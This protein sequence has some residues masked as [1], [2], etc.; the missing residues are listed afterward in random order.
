M[1][2]RNDNG[3]KSI[4]PPESAG[5]ASLKSPPGRGSPGTA[6]ARGGSEK[7]EEVEKVEKPPSLQP[8]LP[9]TSSGLATAARESFGG[10]RLKGLKKEMPQL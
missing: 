4:S 7:V 10:R 1:R 3:T 5:V 8:S 2:D 9:S 6:E